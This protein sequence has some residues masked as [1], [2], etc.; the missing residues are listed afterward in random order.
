LPRDPAFRLTP[1]YQAI[2]RELS[3]ALEQAS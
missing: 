2:C 1:A 3:L